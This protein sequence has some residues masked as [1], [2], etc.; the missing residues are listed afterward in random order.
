[1]KDQCT[2][3]L[4]LCV[5]CTAKRCYLTI[6]R[7]QHRSTL[8]FFVRTLGASTKCQLPE[9]ISSNRHKRQQHRTVTQAA[10]LLSLQQQ[11]HHSLERSSR[12]IVSCI[13]IVRLTAP[14]LIGLWS[15]GV[16][17]HSTE[18]A[19]RH[20]LEAQCAFKILMIH[21]VLQFALRIAFRCVLH[22]CGSLDIRC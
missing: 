14:N 15:S 11:S 7:I 16:H 2:S 13:T 8:T 6:S 10:A 4:I 20:F 3:A 12:P 22:R 18:Y 9:C 1:M 19:T 5:P 21:E 17:G